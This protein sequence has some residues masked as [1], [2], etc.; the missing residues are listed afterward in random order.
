[1]ASLTGYHLDA[2]RIV[3][4]GWDLSELLFT[5]AGQ[6]A[7]KGARDR[8]ANAFGDLFAFSDARS[9]PTTKTIVCSGYFYHTSEDPAASLVGVRLGP[10]K[11][12]FVTKGS[13][14]ND[15]FPDAA[16]YAA[17]VNH[18]AT[19]GILF[20]VERDMS[21]VLPLPHTSVEYKQWAPVLMSM[22]ADYSKTYVT[23][24][25][26]MRKGSSADRFPC[27]NPGC[28]PMPVCCKCA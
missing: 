22:A 6:L 16:C 3:Y 19:G 1:M 5:E 24:A 12:H 26:E 4:D 17:S 11:L 8:R 28:T 9:S 18:T 13:H 2:S 25:S 21:E 15:D 10:W 27:C 7:D 23:A 20:N 14:C